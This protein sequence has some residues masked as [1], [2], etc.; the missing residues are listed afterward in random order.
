M[1]RKGAI[2]GGLVL[3]LLVPGLLIVQKERIVREGT[4][5]SS[6]WRPATRARSSRGTT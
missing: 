3:V 2:L 4:G 6:N 5:C 1:I